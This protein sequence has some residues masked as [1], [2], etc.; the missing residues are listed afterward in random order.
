LRR[1]MRSIWTQRSNSPAAARS[2]RPDIRP[3]APDGM[4]SSRSGGRGAGRALSRRVCAQRAHKPRHSRLPRVT[5]QEWTPS[6]SPSRT[7]ARRRSDV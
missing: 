7:T 5:V 1:W 2:M 6:T 3:S 4:R